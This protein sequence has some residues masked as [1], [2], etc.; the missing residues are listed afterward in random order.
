MTPTVNQTDTG[1]KRTGRAKK[2]SAYQESVHSTP[3]TEKRVH[4]LDMKEYRIELA[5]HKKQVHNAYET[6]LEIPKNTKKPNTISY[7]S[8]TNPR[9]T[10]TN[11][12]DEWI[13]VTRKHK[14]S[15]KNE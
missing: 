9:T 5:Q 15:D 10:P 12:E 1:K 3:S 11:D 14:R 4:D 2:R 6:K 8:E 13:T 7:R